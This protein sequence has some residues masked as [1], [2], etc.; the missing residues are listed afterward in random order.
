MS[1]IEGISLDLWGF[2]V[3]TEKNHL[4]WQETFPQDKTP[5]PLFDPPTIRGVTFT[6]CIFVV[7]VGDNRMSLYSCVAFIVRRPW[8]Q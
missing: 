8:P 2:V 7:I 3:L 5:P 6:S 4:R 1:G